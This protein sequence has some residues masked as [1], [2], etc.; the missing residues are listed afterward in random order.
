MIPLGTYLRYQA[1][2]CE[3]TSLLCWLLSKKIPED[4]NVFRLIQEMRTQRHSAVQTKVCFQ[5]MLR[6]KQTGDF[7]NLQISNLLAAGEKNRLPKSLHNT[8]QVRVSV[9]F[10]C[11]NSSAFFC[12]HIPGTIRVGPQGNRSALQETSAAT[13]EPHQCADPRRHGKALAL[14]GLWRGRKTGCG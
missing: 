5:F 6:T 11:L 13:G 9:L 1:P 3:F 7:V 8:V 10:R 2:Q 12:C 4:F 14:Q